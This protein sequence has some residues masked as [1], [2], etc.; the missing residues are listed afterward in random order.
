MLN[1]VMKV[2]FFFVHLLLWKIKDVCSLEQI[3]I[4]DCR[5]YLLHSVKLPVSQAFCKMTKSG[6]TAFKKLCL[7]PILFNSENCFPSFSLS[8]S[9]LV[10]LVCGHSFKEICARTLSLNS[11]NKL[12]SGDV[13]QDCALIQLKE[14]LQT[15]RRNHSELRLPEVRPTASL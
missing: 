3:Q 4:I 9:P 14:L 7:L 2:F 10:L 6:K 5:I 13:A 15:H 1:N 12:K 11:N 8:V